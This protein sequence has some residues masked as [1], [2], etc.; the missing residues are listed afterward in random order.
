MEGRNDE[1]MDEC[2]EYASAKIDSDFHESD[3]DI[4]TFEYWFNRGIKWRHR[5]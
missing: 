1:E 5:W 3:Q 2:I 4:Y